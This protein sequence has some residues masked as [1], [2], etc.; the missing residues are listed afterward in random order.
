MKIKLQ[1]INNI[2]N[3]NKDWRDAFVDTGIILELNKVKHSAADC[4]KI[5]RSNSCFK[6]RDLCGYVSQFEIGGFWFNSEG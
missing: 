1:K 4:I 6:Y 2:T 3:K 5:K